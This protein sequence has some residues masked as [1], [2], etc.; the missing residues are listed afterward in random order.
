MVSWRPARRPHR[1]RAGRPVG[2]GPVR[3]VVADGDVVHGRLAALVDALGGVQRVLELLGGASRPGGLLQLAGADLG[4]PHDP[5]LHRRGVHVDVLLSGQQHQLVHDLVG[6]R[7][8]DEAVVLHP[9]VPREVERAADPDADAH[10]PRQLLPGRLG[11]VGADHRDR[12]HR[13]AGLEGHP[14]HAGAA[15]VEPT[16]GRPGPLGVDAEQLATAQHPQPGVQ[17]RLAGLAARPVDGQLAHAP[18]ERRRRAPLDPAPGEVVGLGQEGHPPRDHQR[19]E[20]RVREGQVVAR[21]D[22][23]TF[24]GDVLLALD[25]RAEQQLQQRSE[26]DGLEHPVDHCE[27]RPLCGRGT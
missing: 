26:N 9:L 18:E 23:G 5:V 24:L 14:G 10:D 20:D 21:E 4:G 22:R 8:E 16:V 25:P 7:A 15:A 13:D 17:R 11:L 1:A 2:G 6:D 12:E 19:Q 27:T 3:V